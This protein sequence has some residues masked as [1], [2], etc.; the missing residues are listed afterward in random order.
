[1][2]AGL[3]EPVAGTRDRAGA[4]LETSLFSRSIHAW[5]ERRQKAAHLVGVREVDTYC[6]TKRPPLPWADSVADFHTLSADQLHPAYS[7]GEAARFSTF[8]VETPRYL[9]AL[10]LRLS[11][12]GVKIVRRHITDLEEIGDV[13]AIVNASGLGAAALAADPTVFRGDGHV[14]TVRPVP[15][16]ERVFIDESRD[17]RDVAAD[18]VGV[19]MIYII[20]R[21]LDVVIGGTLW[22]HP[23][24][25]GVPERLPAMPKHLLS[26]ATRIE[27]RLGRATPLT[28]RVASRPRRQAGV[29]LEL[30]LT[31]SVPVVHCYGQG[32]SGWTIAPALAEGAVGLLASAVWAVGESA[33]A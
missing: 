27:P 2:A 32:G 14:V 24:A 17:R 26:L 9:A 1:V 23:D 15:G 29:R 11:W 22:D 7:G 33:G 8:V 13:D 4:K 30:D 18:P 31:R 16:V 10:R 20:P 3:I 28:Y 21:R 19:N 12:A 25:D 6:S 5:S